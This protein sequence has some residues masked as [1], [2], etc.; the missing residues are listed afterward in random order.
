VVGRVQG[1]LAVAVAVTQREFR[2]GL[3]DSSCATEIKYSQ[4][5]DF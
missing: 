3:Q 2:I 5:G 4:T 1:K